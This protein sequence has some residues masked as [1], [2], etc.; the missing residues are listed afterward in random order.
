MSKTDH[1]AR[2]K[3]YIA[4]GE[5]YYRKAAGEIVAAMRD[6]PALSQREIGAQVGKSRDWVGRLVR[7]HTNGDRD[8]AP[9]A[10]PGQQESR[11]RSSTRKVLRDPGQRREVIESLEPEERAE[12]ARDALTEAV[13]DSLDV[14]L[15]RAFTE[16]A[17]LKVLHGEG[18]EFRTL[19][20][21]K[22]DRLAREAE[23]W[24]EFLTT[25]IVDA[26]NAHR[27]VR[28]VA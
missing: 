20:A 26:L 15:A 12:V 8:H 2:A 11:D 1:L 21:R 10:A 22:V 17:R 5:D 18:R 25:D 27:K 14:Q 13:D 16:L 4:K 19:T 3:D 28:R 7:W 23:G 6:D 9:F 24:A